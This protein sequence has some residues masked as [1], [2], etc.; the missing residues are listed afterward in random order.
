MYYGWYAELVDRPPPVTNGMISVPPG[1]GLGADL[2]PG[3]AKRK[4]ATSRISRA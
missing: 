1:A 4:D 3:L 2:L